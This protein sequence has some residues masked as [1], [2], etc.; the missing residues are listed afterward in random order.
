ME[1]SQQSKNQDG[2]Q[3]SSSNIEDSFKEFNHISKS[4]ERSISEIKAAQLGNRI[5]FPTSWDRLNKNLLGGLQP[6]KMYVIAGRP[7]VGKSAFSNQ[8]IFDILDKNA[9]KKLLVLY[10]SFEMPDYQQIMRA[11]SNDVK[12]QF[13]QLYSIDSPISDS[14]ISEYENAV[15]KYKKYPIYFCSIP[16]NMVKIKEINNRVNIKFP[17]H[18]IIN[19][20]DHSRLILGTEDTELQKLNQ[21]S[22]TCMWLQARLGVVNILLSQL[23]RNIE[24]EYRAKQQYQ[25]QLT[26]LFGGDSIGQDAHVVMMLQRPYDLYGITEAYCGENPVGLLACHVEKNRDGQL[27]MIPFESDLSTFSIKERIKK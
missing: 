5:V 19:L 25:P 18:T 3:G 20:F 27:G 16:Q 2:L 23:N 11:A 22:K 4:V 24:Q 10:W 6:G 15:S 9:G 13:S 7:G 21:I 26:D 17:Q 1:E 12:M 8:L 14:K